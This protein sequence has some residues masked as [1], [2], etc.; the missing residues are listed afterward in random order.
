MYNGGKCLNSL[1][2]QFIQENLSVSS[3]SAKSSTKF[4][5]DWIDEFTGVA[6]GRKFNQRGNLI[7]HMRMHKGE[8]LFMCEVCGKSFSTGS[9]RNDHQRRHN[10]VKPYKCEYPGCGLDFYRRY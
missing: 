10:Q 2:R 7:Q 4:P 9:N 5:C 8:R 6:C 3:I 1:I